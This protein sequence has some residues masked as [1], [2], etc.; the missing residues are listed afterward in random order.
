MNV[1]VQ[2]DGVYIEDL[3]LR[4]FEMFLSDEIE[5]SIFSFLVKELYQETLKREP[6]PSLREL[7]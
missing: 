1:V 3:F 5:P 2:I 6:L 4:Y 7:I